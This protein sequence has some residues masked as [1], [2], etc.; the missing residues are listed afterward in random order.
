MIN[1]DEKEDDVREYVDGLSVDAMARWICLIRGIRT[2]F[3]KLD[4]LNEDIEE[5]L[6][7]KR[8]FNRVERCINAYVEE[9]FLTVKTDIEIDHQKLVDTFDMEEDEDV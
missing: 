5:S 7:N 3:N 1:N 6:K 2:V 4:D 9:Q 8:F